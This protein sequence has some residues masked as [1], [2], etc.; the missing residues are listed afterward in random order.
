M[1]VTIEVGIKNGFGLVFCTDSPNTNL[2]EGSVLGRDF[3]IAGWHFVIEGK[4]LLYQFTGERQNE[5]ELFDG[6]IRVESGTN[7]ITFHPNGP[8]ADLWRKYG[9]HET[10]FVTPRHSKYN[11]K[12]DCGNI[13]LTLRWLHTDGSVKA[14]RMNGE[15]LRFISWDDLKQYRGKSA[16]IIP[17]ESGT[18]WALAEY[19]YVDKRNPKAPPQTYRILYTALHTTEEISQVLDAYLQTHNLTEFDVLNV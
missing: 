11:H 18:T 17:S 16:F 13:A 15:K 4:K 2:N 10:V 6:I 19:S 3:S 8:S 12:S 9:I 14:D 5:C 7:M 1:K